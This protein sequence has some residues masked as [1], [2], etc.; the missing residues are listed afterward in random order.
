MIVLKYLSI[1]SRWHFGQVVRQFRIF[2]LHPLTFSICV[3]T[4]NWYFLIHAAAFSRDLVVFRFVKVQALDSFEKFR[5]TLVLFYI[6][7][8]EI[9]LCYLNPEIP[10]GTKVYRCCSCCM[11][12]HIRVYFFVLSLLFAEIVSPVDP[13]M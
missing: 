6:L 5:F 11:T 10:S 3:R 8:S 13:E 1:F 9:T 12:V 4:D 2:L 7:A